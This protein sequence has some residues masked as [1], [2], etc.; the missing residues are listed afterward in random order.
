MHGASIE[1]LRVQT[2]QPP[3]D[4]GFMSSGHLLRRALRLLN[5]GRPGRP[6]LKRPPSQKKGRMPS[7][8]ALTNLEVSEFLY[9]IY[10]LYLLIFPTSSASIPA[11]PGCSP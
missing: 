11:A 4:N 8:P 3:D 9:L 1:V 2:A 6:A 10:L 7:H 5:A